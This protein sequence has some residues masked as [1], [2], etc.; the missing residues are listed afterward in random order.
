ML[1]HRKKHPVFRI[2]YS[3]SILAQNVSS[4][5][6]IGCG[7]SNHVMSCRICW[8]LFACFF[9]P[10]VP[11]PAKRGLLFAQVKLVHLACPLEVGRRAPR[12]HRRLGPRQQEVS[13]RE[14]ATYF[15]HIAALVVSDLDSHRK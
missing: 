7:T 12:R 3:N 5:L 15:A 10:P 11:K 6:C 9:K 4:S 1:F 2:I 14:T 13:P 8:S